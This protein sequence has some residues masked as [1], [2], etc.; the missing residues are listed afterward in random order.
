MYFFLQETHSDLNNEVDWGLWWKGQ[1]MLSH[2]TNF[3]AGVATLFAQGLGVKVLSTV[4]V[5]QGR[6]LMIKAEILKQ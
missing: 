6:A 3:S 4:E 2:G 5:V 1:H